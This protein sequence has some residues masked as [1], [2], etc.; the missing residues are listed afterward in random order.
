[1]PS[2]ALNLDESCIGSIALSRVKN[3]FIHSPLLPP[4][5]LR[6][7]ASR[8]AHSLPRNVGSDND[9]WEATFKALGCRQDMRRRNMPS[10]EKRE[11]QDDSDVNNCTTPSVYNGY[12]GVSCVPSSPGYPYIYRET[13]LG[14]P[15]VPPSPA[16]T[17]SPMDFRTYSPY[18]RNSFYPAPPAPFPPLPCSFEFLQQSC[19]PPLSPSSKVIYLSSLLA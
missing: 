9:A 2:P 5:P 15:C 11:V 10:A 16:L 13:S 12:H 6:N 4:T 17:A 7:A 19:G 14:Y 1:L 18:A 3:T 8:R